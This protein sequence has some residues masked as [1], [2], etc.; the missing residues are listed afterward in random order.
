MCY[1]KI[2]NGIICFIFFSSSKNRPDVPYTA[3]QR[4]ITFVVIIHFFF[5]LCFFD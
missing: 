2:P 5:F 3:K 4:S 1:N